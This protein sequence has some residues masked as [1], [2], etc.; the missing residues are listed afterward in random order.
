MRHARIRRIEQSWIVRNTM[1]EY[2]MDIPADQ[3]VRW[4]K[5]EMKNG[6]KAWQIRASREYVHDPKA[7][8]ETFGLS[9]EADVASIITVGTL[10]A[11]LP[12]AHGA[13]RLRIRVEDA[14]GPHTPDEEPV[15]EGPEEID[16][17]AFNAEFVVSD[18]GTAFVTLEAETE[19]GKRQFDRL[20]GALIRN[21]HPG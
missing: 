10:Q 16:L 3:V 4:L 17:D 12:D 8:L 5:E 9:P 15:P 13:W 6:K 19:A 11:E 18:R 1:T 21:R 7:D 2:P 14:I 20:Y